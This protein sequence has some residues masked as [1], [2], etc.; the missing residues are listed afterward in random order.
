[1]FVVDTNVLLY[2][3]DRDAPAHG[4]CRELI[5]SWRASA[6]AWHV[7]WPIVYEFLR[8]IT[9]PR[10]YRRPWTA[11]GAM[12]F[13]DAMLAA[14]GLAVLSPTERHAENLSELLR[15][16]PAL[17][18]NVMYDVHTVT[19]MREHG[20]RAIYT[21][22]ADFHRFPGIEVIDPLADADV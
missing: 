4:R 6:R 2:A 9:H 18:G 13:V 22:D 7:T 10:V 5:E 16:M 20:V 17:A 14:P 12:Q 1:L 15:K 21:R 19:L 3:A 11:K 8:V